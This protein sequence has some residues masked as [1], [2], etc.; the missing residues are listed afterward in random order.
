MNTRILS[1]TSRFLSR[2]A[3]LLSITAMGW[4]AGNAFAATYG[5]APTLFNWVSSAGHTAVT[6]GGSAQC[7]AWNS[8]PVDDDGTAPIN[9]G[10]TFT[11]GTTDYT[12]VRINSNARLRPD[13]ETA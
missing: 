9:I 13:G 12:Q 1:R 8:A 7:A 6:W 5:N 2:V 3:V 11:F 10:F 4:L